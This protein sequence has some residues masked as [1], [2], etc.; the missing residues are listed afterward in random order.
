[1]V[2]PFFVDSKNNFP[3]LLTNFNFVFTVAHDF[4]FDVIHFVGAG[5]K[6]II[7][8][9]RFNEQQQRQNLEKMTTPPKS[10]SL[11][12][13]L[14]LSNPLLEFFVAESRQFLENFRRNGLAL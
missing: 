10:H 2:L 11:F 4:V 5:E 14:F 8:D 6:R 1:M 3:R 9:G 13:Y 7:I 12:T